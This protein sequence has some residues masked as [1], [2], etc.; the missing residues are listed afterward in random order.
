MTAPGGRRGR[1]LIVE[2]EA[3][4]AMLAEDLLIELGFEVLGPV[5]SL[6]AALDMVA[7]TDPD[8][9]LLDVNLRGERVFPVAEAL[10]ARGVPFV[11]ASGYAGGELPDAWAGHARLSKP[12]AKS[13]LAR[14]FAAVGLVPVASTLVPNT[15]S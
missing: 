4:V 12:Y 8:A 10:S 5:G 7:R 3:M 13:E 14:A 1:I 9:A 15:A 11:F 6:S 2:D